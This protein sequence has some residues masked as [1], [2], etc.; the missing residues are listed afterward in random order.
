MSTNKELDLAWDFINKTNK[1]IFLTGKAGTGK[2]TFLHRI[3]ESTLKRH[4]VVAP[5]GVAA[6]N[7]KGT[8]IHSFFQMPFGPILPNAT[9]ETMKQ[10]KF[11]KR[12]IDIIRSLDLLIIDEISM[13]RADLLDGIDQV[14]R[15]YKNRSKVFGGVQVLMIGDLQQLAPVVKDDEWNMLRPHYETMYFFS[16]KAFKE[17]EAIS[18]ELKHIYRQQNQ[19]FIDILNEIRNNR[20]T[21]NSIDELNKRYIPDFVP[22]DKEGYITLTTHN[23]QSNE[24]NKSK[25]DNIDEDSMFYEA[26]VEGDFS[27]HNYPTHEN[28]ELK[29]GSQVMFVKNDSDIE[30][31]YFN[32]KIGKIVGLDDNKV[33][34]RCPG[35]IDDIEATTE[36][37]E[38]IT[39]TID[40][41]SKEIVENV[42]GSFEQIPLKL[43][44][45]I[46]IHKSQGLTFDKAVI[47]V[48]SSFAHGQTYVALS[49]CRTLEGLVLRSPIQSQ[50]IIHD[51]TVTLFT[52]NIEENPP[53]E[54]DLKNA[55]KEF[56][57]NLVGELFDFTQLHY[58]IY[59][60]Q[61]I[62][63]QN[64]NTLRG[65]YLDPIKIIKENGID[66]LIKIGV[67]FRNQ[68]VSMSA[69]IN[70]PLEDDTIKTRIAKGMEYFKN[71]IEEFIEKPF[72][73]L[74]FSTDNKQVN[75]DLKEQIKKFNELLKV[76]EFCFN[77]LDG[78]FNSKK[79]MQLRNDAVF[80]KIKEPKAVKNEV[81]TTENQKLFDQLREFRTSISNS[82]DIPLF[83]VFT[84]DTLYKMCSELPT[85]PSQLRKVKGMGKIRVAKYGEE[86]I[87][88]IKDY[89]DS[90]NIELTTPIDKSSEEKKKKSQKK[91]DT[92]K[93]SFDLYKSG[94]NI[95]EI[96]KERNLKASTIESHLAKFIID[97]SI[98]LSEL[99]GN[100]KSEEIISAI[101]SHDYEELS[102]SELWHKLDEKYSY[103][104]LRM[105]LNYLNPK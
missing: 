33:I 34:V 28:L 55:K 51:N 21:Q 81:K 82:E 88:I 99:L 92:Y 70:N 5:T 32:G 64:Q 18:I 42:K 47:D 57:L 89:C 15:R 71:Q 65:N 68:L 8:T 29:V 66:N 62:A 37:W 100:E 80:A 72:D 63:Y 7:A 14:L 79:Y 1:N 93:V 6:I 23:N 53:N 102:L 74:T 20:I 77:G 104:E 86:I 61:Q 60:A 12:K 50:S 45:A 13:V 3:K 49:R 58:P 69:D 105:A 91:G 41:K 24:I 10:R 25:L 38:N 83:Q 59:R 48:K 31:R 26:I 27:E 16:S 11:N 40:D 94:L 67:S 76:K 30:K 97:G 4:V 96:A 73:D 19:K 17:S 44:W 46:T 95:N 36:L 90:E 54:K 56:L 87:E 52:K 22:D 2:T 84:Q 101:K 98:K 78:K 103:G 35:D 43:A 39:Y 75:K 85:T 9:N